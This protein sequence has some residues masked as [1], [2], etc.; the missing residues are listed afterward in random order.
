MTGKYTVEGEYL[1]SKWELMRLMAIVRM[2]DCHV[3]SGIEFG[4]IIFK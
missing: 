4:E 2:G 1:C 3:Y